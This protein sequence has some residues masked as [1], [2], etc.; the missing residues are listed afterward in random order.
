MASF[1]P[2]GSTTGILSR[3]TGRLAIRV[4]YAAYDG[5]PFVS[6]RVH[7]ASYSL[8]DSYSALNPVHQYFR[9]FKSAPL[10]PPD[11][12][13]FLTLSYLTP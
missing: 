1:I 8:R 10:G 13:I 4:R 11:T 5:D 9:I 3:A 7:A 2:T 12:P 6:H